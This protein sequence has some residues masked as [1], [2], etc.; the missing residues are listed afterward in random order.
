MVKGGEGEVRQ[1]ELVHITRPFH[2][3]VVLDTILQVGDWDSVNGGTL[4]HHVG[5]VVVPITVFNL[6]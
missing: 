5:V 6:T 2:P 1:G 4:V 3:V